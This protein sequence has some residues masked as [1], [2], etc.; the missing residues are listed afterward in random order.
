MGPPLS[1]PLFAGRVS[2]EPMVQV[3]SVALSS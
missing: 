3:F 2:G 1:A